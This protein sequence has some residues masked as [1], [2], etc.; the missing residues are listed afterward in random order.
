MGV[1]EHRFVF[2]KGKVKA[3]SRYPSSRLTL[4]IGT[5]T[6]REWLIYDVGGARSLV[7]GCTASAESAAHSLTEARVVPVFR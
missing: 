7:S 4:R 3:L 6:G 5:E 1:Q 2:E